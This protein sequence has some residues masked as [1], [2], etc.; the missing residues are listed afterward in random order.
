MATNLSRDFA[1]R[2]ARPTNFRQPI[3]KERTVFNYQIAQIIHRER[4]R[5]IERHIVRREAMA[6][7]ARV[8]RSR[9]IRRSIGRR[10]VDIGNAIAAEGN[11]GARITRDPC[12][13]LG[14]LTARQ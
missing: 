4:Q 13:S 3:R 1:G 9:S 8:I 7:R 14:E 11:R 2:G 6:A 5:E 12:G 10:V